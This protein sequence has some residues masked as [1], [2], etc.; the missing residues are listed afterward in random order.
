MTEARPTAQANRAIILF[1]TAQA[2]PERVEL[3]AG[4]LS[5][6]L[7]NGASALRRSEGQAPTEFGG[8]LAHRPQTDP[9]FHGVIQ[10]ASVIFDPEHDP[11]VCSLERDT[12]APR[13]GV[14][15][16]VGECLT[17]DAVER[18]FD[19]GRQRPELRIDLELDPERREL[20][21][22]HAEGLYQTEIVERRWAEVAHDPA[23]VCHGSVSL[24]E[25]SL[26]Q[27]VALGAVA[28][29]GGLEC[30][31]DPCERGAESVVQITPDAPALLLAGIDDV[32]SR[33]L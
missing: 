1:G 8:A 30:E 29:V 24:L 4:P 26:E 18:H 22:M 23:Y 3:Q 33:V 13:T 28:V 12:A 10:P 9:G 14:M 21:A 27:S 25:G 17:G 6:T 20:L 7:E 19:S 15:H 32:L 5:M 16:D 31:C 11:S 2:P